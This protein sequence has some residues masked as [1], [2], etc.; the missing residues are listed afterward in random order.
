M[1]S[2]VGNES[3]MSLLTFPNSGN[4]YYFRSFRTTFGGNFKG[5]LFW[6]KLEETEDIIV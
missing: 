3:D 2:L 6:N 5:E 1:I 4:T